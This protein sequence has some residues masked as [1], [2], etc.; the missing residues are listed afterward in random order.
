MTT[1]NKKCK[2]I[3]SVGITMLF[4]FLLNLALFDNFLNKFNFNYAKSLTKQVK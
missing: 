4:I 1:V 2:K 3:N